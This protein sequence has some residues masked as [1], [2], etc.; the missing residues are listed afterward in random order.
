[1]AYNSSCS[2]CYSGGGAKFQY[3]S[4]SS[5]GS[6]SY[7]VKKSARGACKGTCMSVGVCTCS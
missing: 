2:N 3:I 6:S 4:S 7:S 1:M 5:I